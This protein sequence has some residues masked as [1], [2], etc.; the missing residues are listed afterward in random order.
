MQIPVRSPANGFNALNVLVLRLY[1]MWCC[2]RDSFGDIQLGCSCA[3]IR[4]PFT[5]QGWPL[6]LGA[7]VVMLG[8]LT[9]YLCDMGV[10]QA[11]FPMR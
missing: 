7:G 2:C 3:P 11:C 1:C 10:Y 5:V 6:Q 8:S 9:M 4:D